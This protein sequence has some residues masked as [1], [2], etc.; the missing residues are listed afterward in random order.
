L[1][2]EETAGAD[3]K[4]FDITPEEFETAIIW[5]YA[6]GDMSSW[7]E[8]IDFNIWGQS[9]VL[10]TNED[11]DVFILLESNI[12]LSLTGWILNMDSVATDQVN[13]NPGSMTNY[14]EVKVVLDYEIVEENWGW[15]TG[16]GVIININDDP[17]INKSVF[18]EV[19][20]IE[21]FKYEAFVMFFIVFYTF[22][23]RIIGKR[24]K[25]QKPFD[26]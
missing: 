8:Y 15:E 10:D 22:L 20:L 23:M 21:I 5:I 17:G 11:D 9:F 4:T 24:A 13:Y 7:S 19:T 14:Y 25:Q 16:T 18:D 3:A 2:S 12:N 6:R 1:W 26:F